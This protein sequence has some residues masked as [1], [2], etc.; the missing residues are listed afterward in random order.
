M[1]DETVEPVEP[2]EVSGLKES[3]E[4]ENAKLRDRLAKLDETV[5][6]TV[7]DAKAWQEHQDSLKS[8]EE[9]LAG[10][11]ADADRRAAEAEARLLR[12]DIA[13]EMGITGEFFD[14]LTA[15]D[16]DAIRAQATKIAPLIQKDPFPRPD[17]SQGSRGA[18]KS[19]TADRFASQMEKAGF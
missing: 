6:R 13:R 17:P 5:K 14:L 2:S 16:E 18:G 19:S 8:R 11:I 7:T 10:Q 3:L 4:A 15:S 9:Q 12:A 1:S